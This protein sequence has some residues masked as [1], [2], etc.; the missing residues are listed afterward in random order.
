MWRRHTPEVV[1]GVARNDVVFGNASLQPV[2]LRLKIGFKTVLGIT[3]EVGHVE[4][5]FGQLVDLSQ[6]FPRVTDCFFLRMNT[7]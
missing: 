2:L 1:L 5:L 4:L 6:E 7:E 3:F